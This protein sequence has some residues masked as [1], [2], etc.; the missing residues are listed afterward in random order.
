MSKKLEVSSSNYENLDLI[1]TA[2]VQGLKKHNF[3]EAQ[4]SCTSDM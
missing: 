3:T 2:S 4:V 1:G